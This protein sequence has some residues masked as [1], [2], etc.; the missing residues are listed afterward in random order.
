MQG[1]DLQNSFPRKYTHAHV[2]WSKVHI[3]HEE[4]ENTISNLVTSLDIR[5]FD[6]RYKR[7]DKRT[8]LGSFTT[9]DFWLEADNKKLIILECDPRKTLPE[10]LDVLINSCNKHSV[11]LNNEF[12]KDGY[13]LDIKKKEII[14]KIYRKTNYN[15]T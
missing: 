2:M 1:I 13:F 7:K 5:S 9:F 10:F 11:K 15:T 12:E 8:I 4:L 3:K 6:F 14:R